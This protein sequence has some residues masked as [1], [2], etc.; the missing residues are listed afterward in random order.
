VYGT[1]CAFG[2]VTDP[3]ISQRD[4]ALMEV[5]AD[6]A[7]LVIEPQ[8]RR[9]QRE[10]EIADRLAPV[11][12]DGGP[13]VVLQP[14]VDLATGTRCGAEALSRFPA[15]WATTPDVVFADAHTIGA[16]DRLELLALRRAAALLGQVS[17]YVSMNISPGTLLTPL[18]VE[19]LADLPLDRVVLELSEHDPVGD[20]DS[21]AKALAPLRARGMRLAIDD[22]GAGFSS[23][24]HILVTT[25]DI[26]KID[27]SIVSGLD[28]DPVRSKLA[29]SLVQFAHSARI[30]VIAEGVE[31]AAERD[32]LQRLGVDGGQ[33]WL[34]GRPGPADVL[35]D[36][37]TRL[38][39]PAR[40][41]PVPRT[42]GDAVLPG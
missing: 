18:A 36:A 40:L 11:M 22:V 37:G 7:A 27:R 30:D 29:Q 1:F 38:A 12:A 10:Q 35:V 33:G 2:L 14:I 20:Y 16:G 15:A 32:V 13:T 25:P 9:E 17:G 42:P 3:E 31:T 5:L 4:V 34:F 24:R 19:L 28:A 6:A 41:V 23:L 26:I 8:V 21:L 39:S